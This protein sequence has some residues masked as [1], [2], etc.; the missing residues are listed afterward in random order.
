VDVTRGILYRG[1]PIERNKIDSSRARTKSFAPAID[2][3]SQPEY[4]SIER[5]Q[6]YHSNLLHGRMWKKEKKRKGK[7]KKEK[8]RKKI[9]LGGRES[10]GGR[11]TRTRTARAQRRARYL[12]SADARIKFSSE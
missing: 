12:R 6:F 4:Y 3:D 1:K 11:A 10:I 9:F 2:I 7:K 8:R 5:N